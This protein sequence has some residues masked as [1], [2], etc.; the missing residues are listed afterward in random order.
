MPAPALPPPIR[1]GSKDM[2]RG[3]D[4]VLKG[5][6]SRPVWLFLMTDTNFDHPEKTCLNCLT[7]PSGD[8]K[9]QGEKK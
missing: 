1:R 9:Y 2:H 4:A 3:G 5:G 7:P 8:L 6:D